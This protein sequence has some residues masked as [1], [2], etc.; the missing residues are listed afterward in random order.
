MDE[1]KDGFYRCGSE[2]RLKRKDQDSLF[3]RLKVPSLVPES[4]TRSVQI[5]DEYRE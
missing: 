1:R 5:Q 4:L 2:K 3:P